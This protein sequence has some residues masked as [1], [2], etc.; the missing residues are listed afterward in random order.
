[1]YVNN[2]IGVIQSIKEISDISH[3]VDAV[4]LSD[5]TQAVGRIPVNVDDFGIDIMCFSGHKMY[6]PKGIGALYLRQKKRIFKISS[7]FHGGG[8]E[9]GLEVEHSMFRGLWV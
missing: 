9:N 5:C 3:S 6:A 1:M 2:E 7:L 4:F 8:H